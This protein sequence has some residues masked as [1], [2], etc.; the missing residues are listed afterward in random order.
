MATLITQKMLN[1]ENILADIDTLDAAAH[2]V[3]TKLD[4]LQSSKFFTPEEMA[5]NVRGIR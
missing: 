5:S 3:S 2:T 1:M 4:R